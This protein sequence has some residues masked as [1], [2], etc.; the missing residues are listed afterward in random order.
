MVSTLN[1]QDT[2]AILPT[3]AGKSLCYQLPA[4]LR[5]GLTVVISPLIALMKDQV[6]QL[7]A[8]GV[9]ATF[10]N[11]SLD[12]N[13]QHQ[14]IKEL[15]EGRYKLLY[16]APERVMA[17]NFLTQLGQWGTIFDPITAPCVNCVAP[18]RRCRSL[19]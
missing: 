14:R 17:G 1:G 9:A 6:D 7:L 2:V 13:T 10:L 15:G 5:N 16:I 8:A 12:A 11:S 18:I 19:R 4:L 3:G